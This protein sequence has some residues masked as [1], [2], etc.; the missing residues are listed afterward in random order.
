MYSIFLDLRSELFFPFSAF[1]RDLESQQD[2]ILPDPSFEGLVTAT[3]KVITMGWL[4]LRSRLNGSFPH[5]TSFNTST[6][7]VEHIKHA[8][9]FEY[10]E[11]VKEIHL[12]YSL[13]DTFVPDADLP[14]IPAA[15]VRDQKL[16]HLDGQGR[17]WI[18]VDNV[19]YD[20]TK[21]INEHPGGETVIQSFVGE[22][23]SWQFWRF[24]DKTVMEQWGRP[25]RVGRTE[26]IRN[27]FK[28][29]PKYFG[30]SRIR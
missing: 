27:R 26:G 14:F 18:V 23:C 20:C 6:A 19:V 13:Q 16:S 30:P 11:N 9:D 1:P 12:K 17:A 3:I 5:V 29:I 22:D 28:E 15:V 2:G 4:S 21:F 7:H 24:H 25:L 8:E 10:V